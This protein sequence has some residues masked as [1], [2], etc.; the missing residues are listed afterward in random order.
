MKWAKL[1]VVLPPDPA[2]WWASARTYLPT[3]RALDDG[4]LRVFFAGVDSE[5]VGRVGY[6]DLDGDDPRRVL[7]VSEE[8]IVDV[9]E[10]GTF[11]DRGVNAS[12][13]VDHNGSTY[14]YYLG[15][16][17]GVTV[18]YYVFTGLAIRR[19][20]AKLFESARRVPVLDRTAAEPFSRSAPSVLVED[21]L[22]RAWYVSYGSWW[23]DSSGAVHYST[24]IRVAVSTDGVGWAPEGTVCL[25]PEGDDYAVTR[26]W[27]LRDGGRYRMWYSIRSRAQPYRLGYAESDD[28]VSWERMD[29]RVGLERSESGW[30]SE[31]VCCPC[32]VDSGGHRYLFYNGNGFGRDGFGCAEL[33]EL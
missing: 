3:A 15:W 23:S 32:V 17:R 8:P 25:R 21:G 11:D 27:V 14:L 12:S 6:C 16:Q 20:D 28:G 31:M 29:H 1:G 5:N 22:F 19:G 30:D 18:P 7:E 24:D 9:G 13:V 2:R 10:R 26:P 33:E 4:R